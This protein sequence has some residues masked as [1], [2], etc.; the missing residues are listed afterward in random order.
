HFWFLHS[1]GA[2]TYHLSFEIAYEHRLQ[3]YYAMSMLQKAFFPSEIPV[4]KLQLWVHEGGG[5]DLDTFLVDEGKTGL[6]EFVKTKFIKHITELIPGVCGTSDKGDPWTQL[7]TG[8]HDDDHD[9]EGD[10]IRPSFGMAPRSEFCREA[11]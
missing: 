5:F 6:P 11:F 3:H 8:E 4:D 7:V 2:L 9:K 1:N 10:P